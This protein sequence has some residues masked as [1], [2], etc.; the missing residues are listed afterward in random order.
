MRRS[1]DKSLIDERILQGVFA[2][3]EK[4]KQMTLEQLLSH[5]SGLEYDDRP[6]DGPEGEDDS[7]VR[8]S[9]LNER[10]TYQGNWM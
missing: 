2:D 7:D 8:L 1:H 3:P 5:T 10:F 4:A 9:T 6:Q